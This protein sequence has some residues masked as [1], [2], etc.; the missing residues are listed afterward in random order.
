MK[1]TCPSDNIEWEPPD[2]FV[3]LYAKMWNGLV[4]L[5]KEPQYLDK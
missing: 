5:F 2:T 3:E 1:Y 4:E